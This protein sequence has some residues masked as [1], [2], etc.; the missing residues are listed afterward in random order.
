LKDVFES[1]SKTLLGLAYIGIL[2]GLMIGRKLS[3]R[4]IIIIV[5]AVVIAGSGL[6]YQ[7]TRPSEGVDVRLV[8]GHGSNPQKITI[9]L[10]CT[11]TQPAYIYKIIDFP[12]SINYTFADDI[13]V[14]PGSEVRITYPSPGGNVILETLTGEAATGGGIATMEGN[15]DLEW[16]ESQGGEPNSFPVTQYGIVI[17]LTRAGNEYR[18]TINMQ[19]EEYVP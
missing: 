12:M 7:F 15:W 10:K 19:S 6:I 2:G 5:V 8:V 18:H 11:G 9:E 3:A 4:T 14:P 1:V 17:V 16:I 13:I